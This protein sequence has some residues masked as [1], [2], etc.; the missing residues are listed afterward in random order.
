MKKA[1]VFK[2]KLM[3]LAFLF[4]AIGCK[5]DDDNTDDEPKDDGLGD[6]SGYT[7][8]GANQTKFFNNQDE[9][10][11]VSSGQNFY[12]QNANYSGNIPEYKD[13]GDGTV[14]D[15]VTGLMWQKSPDT[16]GDGTIDA[17]DKISYNNAL[18][19]AESFS[20][21][22]YEDWRLPTIKE[23]YSLILFSGEDISGYEGTSTDGLQ[24]FIDDAYFDFGYGDLNAGERLIDAQYASSTKYVSTTMNGDETMFGVNFADGRIKGYPIK[25]M[26]ND[27]TFYVIYV[28]GNDEYGTND[29]HDNGN[30]TI[31]DNATNLMWMQKD[32]ENGMNWKDA[33][34]YAENANHAGHSDWRLPTIKELQ[35]IVDYSRSPE[36]TNSAALSSLFKCSTIKNE[37]GET[38]Y[39]YFWS[40]TTHKGSNGK[41]MNACYISFGKALGKMNNWLDVHG[42]GAQ[43]SDPKS[44]DASTYPDG[45]GPQGDAIRINNYVRLVRDVN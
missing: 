35:S 3:L 2:T 16:N 45:H 6:Y 31:T 43:R 17:N 19:G 44:G 34:D 38:D 22:G 21:A 28:R 42:A 8:V 20:L 4:V 37:G 7:I 30:G 39:P 1:H 36:T 33:L 9:I 11:A 41:G 14:T 26:N 40:N 15:L 13:N 32:S 29:L 27:N 23:L 24:P 25:M 5:K 10:S 18:S 12:G